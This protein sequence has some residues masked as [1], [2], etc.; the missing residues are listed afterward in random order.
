LGAISPVLAV[1]LAGCSPDVHDVAAVVRDSAGVQ[2]VEHPVGVDES[3]PTWRLSVEPKL[4]IGAAAGDSQDLL[5][6]IEGAHRLPHERIVVA[7]RGTNELRFY[8]AAGD[9]LFA[10]GRQGAGPGEFEYIA[11]TAYC[12]GL[13]FAYDIGNRRMSVY[14]E[15][16]Q[17]QRDFRVV[18]PNGRPPYG[19]ASCRSGGTFLVMGWY[20]SAAPPPL[21]VHRE[22]HPVWLMDAQGNVLHSLGDFPGPD[23]WGHENGSRP[24]PFGRST[25]IV[26]GPQLAYVGTGGSYEI[27]GFD[28][29]GTIVRVIR[30]AVAGLELNEE[31]I[32]AYESDLLDAARSDNDRRAL[33]RQFEEMQYPQR[34]PAYERLM[35][36]TGD[37]LWVADFLL[38]RD[39]V[40]TWSV[41]DADGIQ[42]AT[43][44][45]AVDLEIREIGDAYVLATMRDELD[46][47]YVQ[48]YSLLKN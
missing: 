39:T 8:D 46:V 47:E 38:S 6:Q 48:L 12:D 27:L 23:R 41:F 9:Y 43:A 2:V 11:W 3:T 20:T 25:L 14:D 28:S 36:D 4:S 31:D 1:I 16:G 33:Q 30:K 24:Q 32:A 35:M 17:L 22:S 37:R 10:A 26:M 7:N 34:L 40:V 44:A 21:G 29:T 45:T 13:L 5:F 15:D 19:P 42:V 18:A